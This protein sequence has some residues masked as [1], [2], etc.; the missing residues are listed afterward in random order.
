MP[1]PVWLFLIIFA[2]L[3]LGALIYEP[4]RKKAAADR[5]ALFEQRKRERNEGGR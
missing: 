2:I 4:R 1:V 3:C 5:K